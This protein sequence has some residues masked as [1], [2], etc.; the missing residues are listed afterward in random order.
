[1]SRPRKII[2]IIFLSCLVLLA[3]LSALA[4]WLGPRIKEVAVQQI[5][6]NLTVPVSVEEIDFSLLRKFPYA[7]VDFRNVQTR[8][9]S[10]EGTTE[11]LLV[12]GHVYLLFNWWEVFGDELRL[13]SISIEKADCNLFVD[14]RGV[15]NYDIFRK[16][17]AGGNA[18]SLELQEILLRETALRYH[19]IRAG[20]DYAFRAG[21]MKCLGTFSEAVYDLE[22]EGALYVERF[23]S[24]GITY[25]SNKETNV[26]VKVRMDTQKGL[27]T[28]SESTLQVEA[29]RLMVDGYFRSGK[30]TLVDL[31][32]QSSDAGLKELLSLVP[33]LYTDKLQDYNYDGKVYFNTRISG[34]IS[35][36][37]Q[38]LITAEFGTTNASLSPKGSPYKLSGLQFA[39]NYVNRIS[40]ARPVERLE[41]RG[42]RG[43][44]EGQAFR[45]ELLAEDFKN[46]SI[47]LTVNSKVDLAVLS[48]FYIPDTLESMSGQVM[49]DARLRGRSR[50]S[51]SWV[52][53]GSLQWLNAGFRLRKSPVEYSGINGMLQLKG[54]RLSLVNLE[55]IAAGSD[56]RLNGFFDNVYAYLLTKEEVVYGEASL[57]ARN[58]DLNELLEDKSNSAA[59]TAYRLDFSD[60]I[61]VKLG[62][63][64]GMLSF[65]KFQA[66]QVKGELHL[67]DK[68][69]YGNAISFKAFEGHLQLNG[70]IDAS[71]RDSIL[72]A[73]DADLKKLD[74]TEAFA[75]LGN[76][77]QEVIR[78]KNVKGKLTASVQFASTWSKDLHCNFNKVYARSKLLIEKGELIDFEPMLALSRYLKG[79]DLRQI[80]FETLQNEIEI[81]NQLITFPGMEIKSS[82]MDLTASGTHSFSNVVDY[83]L[84][85]YLSQIMGR[86]V[87][88]R[89][90]EFGTVQ[91]DGLG[92]MRLFLTM[93]GP[94][95]DPKISYDRKG[96]EQKITKDIRQEKQDLKQILRQEFGWFKKDSAGVKKVENQPQKQEELELDS[97]PE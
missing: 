12:A 68:V 80:K 38:P 76:F 59:D 82:V 24:D 63:S 49:L 36:T 81:S 4:W 35:N 79:A 89:N 39:G 10:T 97:E 9:R 21:S 29:I 37:E 86:K 26:K 96:I 95:S 45:L 44:L 93:K 23:K 88:D 72:I 20:R 7:S 31:K 54:N 5:N 40:A 62:I 77:G 53:E 48:R 22:G 64:V 58:L 71:H 60:R 75:Q 19:N 33:G 30:E 3:L 2:L 94:L 15:E 28:F 25:L 52:S 32:V 66:W 51:A 14:R 34:R 46:P 78:D 87:R 90:T 43:L 92:R 57:S 13:K 8:G 50:E 1:M 6:Q 47:S 85:L 67:R 42:A 41:I 65:R 55:G 56:F 84:Q 11:P 17:E 16:R 70:R 91:D 69:L 74:V 18:F 83:K 27:Y 61:K 73:C